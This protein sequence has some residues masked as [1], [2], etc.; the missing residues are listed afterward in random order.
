VT[1]QQPIPTAG[2]KIYSLPAKL[3]PL[4]GAALTP[5]TA[6]W[7]GGWADGLITIAQPPDKQRQMVEAFRRGGGTGKP[8]ILQVHVSY[9]E[10][11]EAALGNA[12][13]QWRSNVVTA[14]LAENLTTPQQF[15]D[16]AA[17]V[18][19]EDMHE[20]VRISADMRRQLAWVEE[21]F[22]MG[23]ETV[24]LHNVGRNQ[25]AFIKAFAAAGNARAL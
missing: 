23:F 7:V 14:R 15:D 6:E 5:E 22:A 11:D 10:T 18:R 3:P 4:I 24:F 9:A 20:H 12:F 16:A 17:N 25:R 13:D 1:R 21:D 8:M 2:A 19:P